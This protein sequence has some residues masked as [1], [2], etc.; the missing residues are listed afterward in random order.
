[1]IFSGFI[2]SKDYYE[3]LGVSRD[4]SIDEIKKAYKKLAKKY[5]P[6]LNKSP[7]AAEKFKE[8]NEAA[9]VLTDPEK[10]RQYDQFGEAAFKQ[11]GAEGGF[12]GFDFSGFGGFGFDD[13]N[14]IFESF[15]GSGF[16]SRK[17]SSAKSRGSD[18]RYD[19]SLTLEEVA[20][21]VEK[22]IS[23]RRRVPCS[24][25]NGAGGSGSV[26]CSTC[27]GSGY[28]R[29]SRR[30]PF[31]VFSSTS[32]CP[33]CDGQ[34]RTFSNPCSVCD[35]TGVVVK[36]VKI[37]VNIPKGVEDGVR[38]RVAGEGDA[39]VRGGPAGDLYL[40][41]HVKDHPLFERDGADLHHSLTIDFVSAALG[42]DL[43]VPT[44]FGRAKLKV[45]EGTQPGTVFRLKG[46]GLPVMNS[47]HVGDLYVTVDVEIPKKLNSRQRQL[48][49]EFAKTLDDKKWSFF[50][51]KKK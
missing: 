40:F 10:R 26:V 47:S 44:L 16:G 32:V 4:A 1:M 12:G 29:Q 22:V 35:T 48:L 28:V 30:T 34:G 25:C 46:K 33:S 6:D 31:G 38:L 42:A 9:S 39:G 43:E 45:P 18:I 37:K 20:K 51:K 49:E 2:M 23:L 8:I 50:K 11:G 27:H 3:I 19:L 14:D 41:I 13:L 24:A 7:D 36:N 15:F 5:H 21:G 17:R